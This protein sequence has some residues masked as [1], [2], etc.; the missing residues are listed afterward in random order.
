MSTFGLQLSHLASTTF[1]WLPPD[2]LV[3][4]SLSLP[5]LMCSAAFS[6][7]NCA[8]CRAWSSRPWRISSRHETI[9]PF[10]RID[11]SLMMPFSLRLRGTY[12]RPS[13]LACQVDVMRTGFPQSLISPALTVSAPKTAEN[14]SL[15]PSPSRPVTPKTSP[16][17]AVRST[18]RKY[19]SCVTP[20]RLSR[21]SPRCA[22]VPSFSV[23]TSWPTMKRAKSDVVT[24]FTL[25]LATITPSRRTV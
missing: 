18:F 7:S 25:P 23:R 1:C 4:E 17:Y 13:C 12:A 6:R 20:C 11:I 5:I 15:L 10:S 22:P 19:G 9:V 14:S 24:S 3:I 16:A 21:S 8:R 2:R